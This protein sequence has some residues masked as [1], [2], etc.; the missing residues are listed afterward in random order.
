MNEI[1]KDIEGYEGE[2]QVS[3][4]GRVRSLDKELPVF[5]NKGTKIRRGIIKRFNTSHSGYRYVMLCSKGVCKNIRVH[6]LVAQAFIPNPDNMPEVNHK[7][8]DKTN[9]R[10]DNL[11]WCS[12]K[13]NCNYGTRKERNAVWKRRSVLQLDMNG[14]IIQEFPSVTAARIATGARHIA[15]VCRGKLNKTG[16]YRWK[17]KE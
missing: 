3:N 10:A 8:E 7:D 12:P 17:Y 11:E 2:Y 15:E 16:G 6:R 4:L 1:W 13:Y 14:N 9:N 5:G